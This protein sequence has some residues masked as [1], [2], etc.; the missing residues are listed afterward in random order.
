MVSAIIT[1]AGKGTRMN[2]NINKLY[3]E[4]GGIPVLARALKAFDDCCLVNEIILVANED[5]IFYCKQ[6]I[7]DFYAF[8]K[9]KKIVVGGHTR[10]GSVFRGLNEVDPGCGIVL[11]HD[12]AR[13]FIS[14]SIIRKSIEAAEEFGAA[15]VAVPVKDT[16]KKS[17]SDNFILETLDRKEL[18][19][20]QTPQAFKYD[21]ILNAHKKAL[22]DNF[23]GTDDTV[24]V[25]RMGVSPK[26]VMGSY[27]N[28]KITTQE[29]LVIA[30]A[31]IDKA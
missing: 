6:N 18:W 26:L 27:D 16:V 19:L 9:V 14:G 17:G 1:A 31:I 23:E 7:I 4:I 10:Q 21:L 30:Q 5:D 28:I 15:C 2:I 12:G 22:E 24:L 20:A 13:P 11:I 3:I 29:D 25:E 8:Q